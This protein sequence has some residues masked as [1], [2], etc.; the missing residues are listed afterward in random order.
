MRPEA[1]RSRDGARLKPR[2]RPDGMASRFTPTVPG[3][4]VGTSCRVSPFA[5]GTSQSS[6]GTPSLIPA[7]SRSSA[8]G[9]STWRPEIAAR[10]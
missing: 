9:S 7:A 1:F 10:M 6:S 5:V 4:D 8:S 3:A 2:T